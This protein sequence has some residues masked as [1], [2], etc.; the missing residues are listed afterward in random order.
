MS[1]IYLEKV[2][3][4]LSEENKQIAKTW[5]IQTVA[6]QPAHAAGMVAGGALG[7]RLQGK[8]PALV[9]KL[10]EGGKIGKWTAAHL[11]KPGMAMAI[12]AGVGSAA[13]GGLADLASLKA[14]LHGKVK[15]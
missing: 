15:E 6:A 2:A 4:I 1:N 5:G 9:G 11:G 13:A 10:S 8:L 12:G 3:K 14:S 7:A